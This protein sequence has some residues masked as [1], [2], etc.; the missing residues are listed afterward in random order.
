MTD[1]LEK[2]DYTQYVKPAEQPEDDQMDKVVELVEG[3]RE[4]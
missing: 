2:P 1:H 4:I 3:R